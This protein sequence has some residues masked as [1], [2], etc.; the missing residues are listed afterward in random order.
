MA[1]AEAD[2]PGEWFQIAVAL[3]SDGPLI[4]DCA[5]APRLDEPRI[6][7]IGFTIDPA[8]Q[9]QGYAR[10]AVR[11]LLGILFDSLGKHRISASCDPR[12]LASRK[13]LSAVGMRQEGQLIEGT[14]SKGEWADDL[15]FAMLRRE[16]P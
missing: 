3:S 8:H 4:G 6:V 13:V 5:F 16:W 12:N 10:E 9:G 15:V 2:V 1:V 7:D 14:W 11:G